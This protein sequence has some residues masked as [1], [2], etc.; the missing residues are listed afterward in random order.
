MTAIKAQ[1]LFS[2]FLFILLS[3]NSFD[4]ET[5]NWSFVDLPTDSDLCSITICND[6]S[7]HIVGG[8]LWERGIYISS[9]F[10][11]NWSIDTILNK[12]LLA[13]DQDPIGNMYAT[14]I[15]GYR[16]QKRCDTEWQIKQPK[17]WGNMKDLAFKEDG[18]GIIVGGES[19]ILGYMVLNLGSGNFQ[20][21]DWDRELS[22]ITYLQDAVYILTGYGFV[23]KS[24]DGGKNWRQNE[25]GGDFFIDSSFPIL[26]IGY[27]IGRNGT[28]I[29]TRDQGESWETLRNAYSLTTSDLPFNAVYFKDEKTG[30]ICGDQGLVL[31]TKDAGLNWTIFD[32]LPSID[33]LD[34]I[35]DQDGDLYVLGK[36]GVLISIEE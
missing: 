27:V 17:R 36:E 20:T 7:F 5:A 32:N 9:P 35:C 15:D 23:S 8:D 21:I 19:L 34:L 3:C 31:S 6:G 25:V 11:E 29:K 18:T 33:F 1:Y 14:G 13:I 10:G 22:S 24:I 12:Q 26:H 28:I 2:L 30:Y 4:E 16:L